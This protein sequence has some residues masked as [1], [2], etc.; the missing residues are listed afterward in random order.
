MTWTEDCPIPFEDLHLLRVLHWNE[1][2]QVVWGEMIISKRVAASATEVFSELYQ[3]KFPI[4]SM[5]PAVYFD[6]SDEESMAKNNS[7]AFNCRKV[8]RSER[9]SEHSYGEAIDI[10]PL[11][12]PWVQGL[13][14]YPENGKVYTDRSNVI[15]GM[16][17]QGDEVIK[18]FE[19]HGWRWGSKKKNVRDYQHFSRADHQE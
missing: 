9:W 13:I 2:K 7:S 6:G 16:I 12:N 1:K 8:K 15:P 5:K 14:I 19:R 3:L 4:H 18:I 17:N 10:N 11:W